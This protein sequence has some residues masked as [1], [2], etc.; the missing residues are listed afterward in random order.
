MEHEHR[1]NLIIFIISINILWLI[2][3][4]FLNVSLSII[5]LTLIK[6]ITSN[7]EEWKLKNQFT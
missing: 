6:T 1:E 2:S 5:I 3:L 4:L 7:E